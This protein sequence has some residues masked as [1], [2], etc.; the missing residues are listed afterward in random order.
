M[1]LLSSSLTPCVILHKKSPVATFCVDL[2]KFVGLQHQCTGALLVHADVGMPRIHGFHMKR[3][4]DSN[5]LGR[6][7][8]IYEVISVFAYTECS[9]KPATTGF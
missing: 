4:S 6:A 1:F 7:G 9:R 3:T 5:I 8:L 2:C